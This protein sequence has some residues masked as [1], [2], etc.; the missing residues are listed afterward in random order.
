MRSPKVPCEN[1]R[2]VRSLNITSRTM[3]TEAKPSPTMA[4]NHQ[5]F[6]I[7]AHGDDG[8]DESREKEEKHPDHVEEG[9]LAHGSMAAL[10]RSGRASAVLPKYTG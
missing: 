7:L 4:P 5:I 8:P 6:G 2:K 1:D 3:R 9:V 10:A